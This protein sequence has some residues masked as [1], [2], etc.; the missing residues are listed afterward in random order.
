[1][2]TDTVIS[3]NPGDA[4]TAI[5]CCD[6]RGEVRHGA[7]ALSFVTLCLDPL[8]V[9]RR[10]AEWAAE[11]YSEGVPDHDDWLTMLFRGAVV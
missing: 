1:M 9:A 3:G 2:M 6:G 10:R 7:E 11:C 8:C 5:G 4:R